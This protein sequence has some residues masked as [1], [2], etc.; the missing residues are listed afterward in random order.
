[1]NEVFYERVKDIDFLFFK[2]FKEN[3]DEKINFLEDKVV[4]LVGNYCI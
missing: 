2:K 3:F 4:K 1:M